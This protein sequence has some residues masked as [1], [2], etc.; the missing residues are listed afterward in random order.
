MQ[1][2]LRRDVDTPP[3]PPLSRLVA[4]IAL[5]EDFLKHDVHGFAEY[6]VRVSYRVLP[7]PW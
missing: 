4:R 1:R 6:T 2:R 7:G 5:E 3:L